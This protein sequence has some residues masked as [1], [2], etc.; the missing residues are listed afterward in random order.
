M[1]AV[2]YNTNLWK[3]FLEIKKQSKKFFWWSLGIWISLIILAVADGSPA[4]VKALDV[5]MLTGLYILTL[6]GEKN[7]MMSRD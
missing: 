6:V 3:Q 5:T 2:H 4:D 1:N 7:I